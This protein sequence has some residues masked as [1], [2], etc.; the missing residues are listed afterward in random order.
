[1]SYDDPESSHHAVSVL[2]YRATLSV[3]ARVIAWGT[4]CRGVNINLAEVLYRNVLALWLLVLS[5]L[6]YYAVS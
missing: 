4:E 1:M 3:C 5:F 6:L 2:L